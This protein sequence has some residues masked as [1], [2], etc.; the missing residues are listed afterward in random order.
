[1]ERPLARSI[2][3][4]LLFLIVAFFYVTQGPQITLREDPIEVALKDPKHE[5]PKNT[6]VK[7]SAGQE[8][9]TAK[10]DSYLSDKTRVVEEE[11]SSRTGGE[12][13][14]GAQP[15][16]LSKTTKQKVDLS[17]FGLKLRPQTQ[18]DAGKQRNWAKNQLGEV[19]RGGQYIQGM[20]EGE[21][22]ALNTKEFVFYSYFERVR[23]QLDQAWQPILR[24]N[25]HRLLKAGRHLASNSDFVTRAMVTMNQRGEILRIQILE[26][27]GTQDLDQAAI[28]ALNKAG[29]YP[30]PPKGLID[31]SGHVEI[32]WDF[33][34]KT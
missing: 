25:V 2:T 33:I 4:H 5:K 15:E 14:G 28:D 19:L 20:K 17:D 26:E 24:E 23:R 11:L 16:I 27:S 6:I 22:S 12:F 3:F 10:K 34:L 13:T 32:R 29:P 1:M 8:E 30:N 7:R 18:E 21:F 31:S 9:K